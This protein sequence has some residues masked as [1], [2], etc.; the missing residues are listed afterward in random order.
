MNIAPLVDL[1][2]SV[3]I[4]A[5]LV[6]AVEHYL[7]ISRAADLFA[8]VDYHEQAEGAAWLRMMD[9]VAMADAVNIGTATG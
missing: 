9:A 1:P 3:R 6:D 2:A 4:R 8:S 5:E 7:A